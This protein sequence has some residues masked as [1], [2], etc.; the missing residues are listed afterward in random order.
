MSVLILPMQDATGEARRRP[1]G[2]CKVD[3]MKDVEEMKEVEE[4]DSTPH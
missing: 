1:T 4:V 3:E 2:S